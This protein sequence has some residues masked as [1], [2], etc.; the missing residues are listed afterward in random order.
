MGLL[1]NE[2]RARIDAMFADKKTSAEEILAYLAKWVIDR[3]AEGAFTEAEAEKDLE[4][5][6][7]MG[8]GLLACREYEAIVKMLR[9]LTSCAEEG[10][11]HPLWC[12][13]KGMGHTYAGELDDAYRLISRSFEL[14]SLNAETRA[15]LVRLLVYRGEKE[16]AEALLSESLELFP[17]TYELVAIRRDMSAGK[18]FLEMLFHY[19][20]EEQ[21]EALHRDVAS[22][23]YDHFKTFLSTVLFDEEGW[24]RMKRE[25]G[26]LGDSL[27]PS[28]VDVRYLEGSYPVE[29]PGDLKNVPVTILSN[30]AGISHWSPLEMPR[31]LG[32]IF[33]E[34][35]RFLANKDDKVSV[36]ISLNGKV[37]IQVEKPG[38]NVL[39]NHVTMFNFAAD[40]ALTLRE[41][42]S[43]GEELPFE[44]QTVLEK[45]GK[46][47][48]EGRIQ[49]V[50]DLLEA[51]PEET[52]SPL[53][54]SE[55]ARAY[56]NIAYTDGKSEEESQAALRR[57]LGL[58][59]SVRETENR[60]HSWQFRVGYAFY[61]LD[62]EDEA[63]PYFKRAL[64][65]RPG[66]PDTVEFLHH[67]LRE[68][69]LPTPV[70]NFATRVKGFWELFEKHTGAVYTALKE[71]DESH[72]AEI[73]EMIAEAVHKCFDTE[74]GVHVHVRDR[75]LVE[76][77]PN[78]LFWNAI[79]IGHVCEMMPEKLK[80]RW[81]FVNGIQAKPLNECE[82]R[83]DGKPVD[84]DKIRIWVN[85]TKEKDWK[86]SLFMP[87]FE[88]LP[89]NMA[90]EGFRFVNYLFSS[91]FGES[92]V[93]RWLRDIGIK[94]DDI[95]RGENHE[96]TLTQF[97]QYFRETEP[98]AMGYTMEEYLYEPIKFSLKPHDS[99]YPLYD[100]AD[101]ETWCM[102]P[103]IGSYFGSDTT[104][105]N[106]FREHGAT[107]AMIG[108]GLDDETV[109]KTRNPQ[110]AAEKIRERLAKYVKWKGP[111]CA[112]FSGSAQGKYW[113][114]TFF[115]LWDPMKFAQIV[116]EFANLQSVPVKTMFFRS[117]YTFGNP[118]FLRR[119]DVGESILEQEAEERRE[120][121][122]QEAAEERQKAA[123]KAAQKEKGEEGGTEDFDWS[124]E[125]LDPHR[126]LS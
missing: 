62:R 83:F 48:E 125:D 72:R 7:Y 30:E 54:T 66:D 117:F 119:G 10:K 89:Q 51:I 106:H 93:L 87:E 109:A 9:M 86:L 28:M 100:V 84:I 25:L 101:G 79:L 95:P 14:D 91:I 67:C 58:L 20:N 82:F 77:S 60:K 37:A 59:F 46:L 102:M 122:L 49:E 124:D 99:A 56:N 26:L 68:T 75:I 113:T 35:P 23:D 40:K 32:F 114:Y 85:R 11:D 92:V 103:L 22:A 44:V 98:K 15:A 50:I 96:M 94:R 80:D 74:W 6:L 121:A 8:R 39:Q 33:Q 115:I 12:Y 47:N 2:E 17:N 108:F 88:N 65:L 120:E 81:E 21:D 104:I 5:E 45:C 24:K 90:R 34:C 36:E 76:I 52:R 112:T 4:I 110:K 31:L 61:Y 55:L 57:A 78:D 126:V 116:E 19:P 105:M 107:A 70:P 3:V 73:A 64:A 41:A 27:K 1:G 69:S 118:I 53:L 29:V 38:S 111:K 13:L 42:Q 16:R 43:R 18:G 123:Q 97:V 71:A 63:L